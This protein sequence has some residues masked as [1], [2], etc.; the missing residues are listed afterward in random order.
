MYNPMLNRLPQNSTAAGTTTPVTNGTNPGPMSQIRQAMEYVR[1]NG[2]DAK[3]A[4]YRLAQQKGVDP[5]SVLRSL[6]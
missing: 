6:R 3:T 4:F 5:E 1:N 2:G